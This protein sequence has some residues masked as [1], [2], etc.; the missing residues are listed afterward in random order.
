MDG[1]SGEP[2]KDMTR[3]QNS[4]NAAFSII[5]ASPGEEWTARINKRSRNYIKKNAETTVSLNQPCRSAEGT[6]LAVGGDVCC[7]GKYQ[8]QI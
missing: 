6:E 7:D 1:Q 3:Q 5:T 4:S 8:H 2:D